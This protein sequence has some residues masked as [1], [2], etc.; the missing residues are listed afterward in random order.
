[1]LI[2]FLPPLFWQKLIGAKNWRLKFQILSNLDTNRINGFLSMRSFYF[3]LWNNKSSIQLLRNECY[4]KWE[5]CHPGVCDC[6][7]IFLSGLEAFIWPGLQKWGVGE[8]SQSHGTANHHSHLDCTLAAG[9]WLCLQWAVDTSGS[10]GL[11]GPP[12]QRKKRSGRRCCDLEHHFGRLRSWLR[13]VA[14]E[15]LLGRQPGPLGG[16]V[17]REFVLGIRRRGHLDASRCRERLGEREAILRLQLQ[18]VRGWPRV[19]PLHAGGVVDHHKHRLRFGDLRWRCFHLHH[20]QLQS[21]WKLHRRKALLIV[22]LV[23]DDWWFCVAWHFTAPGLLGLVHWGSLM[24]L[25]WLLSP[26]LKCT[27]PRTWNTRLVRDS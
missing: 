6:D 11:P 2:K 24:D 17:W 16:S 22:N 23:P 26:V 1:M 8:Q 15:P 13:A 10:K 9:S 25:Q 27:S 21:T 4:S 5:S 19:R 14:D 12:Q 7:R 3:S 18:F 20:L